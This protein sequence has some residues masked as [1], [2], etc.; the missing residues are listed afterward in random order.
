MIVMVVFDPKTLNIDFD[1]LIISVFVFLNHFSTNTNL[2]L[3][4]SGQ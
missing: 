2:I 4:Y 3:R 1:D